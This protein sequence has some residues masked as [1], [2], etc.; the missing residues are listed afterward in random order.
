LT[1]NHLLAA[2]SAQTLIP[3]GHPFDDLRPVIK[4]AGCA[5]KAGYQQKNGKTVSDH[6]K[7]SGCKRRRQFCMSLPLYVIALV[8]AELRA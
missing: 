3:D 8:I 6:H 4:F 1:P 2:M 5:G 7:I